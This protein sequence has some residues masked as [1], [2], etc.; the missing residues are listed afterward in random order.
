[1]AHPAE[2]GIVAAFY[3]YILVRSFGF[4]WFFQNLAI[5]YIPP[6]C[7][8]YSRGVIPTENS[9]PSQWGLWYVPSKRWLV[10]ETV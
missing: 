8:R 3:P 1:M 6:C 4:L 9:H 2:R 5:F 10:L 7:R